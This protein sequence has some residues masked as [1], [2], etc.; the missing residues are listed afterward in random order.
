MNWK[1]LFIIA[2][3]ALLAVSACKKKKTD[4]TAPATTTEPATPT[5]AANPTP[6]VEPTPH[7][8]PTPPVE[9]TPPVANPTPPAAP[10]GDACAAFVDKMIGC[11]KEAAGGAELPAAALDPMKQGFQQSCDAWKQLP[12]F[13]AEFMTKA[14]DACKDTAC[15]AG[16]SDYMMCISNKITEAVT[17]A[18]TAA[19]VTP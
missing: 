12:G 2:L 16:G 11:A 3:A 17:A 5:P 15:G 7:A 19:A 1:H 18:A 10:A 6:P 13:G 8:N 4:T 9:P 14:M